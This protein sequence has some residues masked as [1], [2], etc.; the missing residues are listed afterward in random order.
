MLSK[1][2][3]KAVTALHHKK[4]RRE[5]NLFIAEGDKVVTE[6]LRA[7]WNVRSLYATDEFFRGMAGEVRTGKDTEFTLVKQSELTRI[8]T[9]TTPQ[10]VLAVVEMKDPEPVN[11]EKGSKLV[12]DMISDPG[13]LGTIIRAADWF[14]IDEVICINGSA[15]LYNPKVVQA[16]MGSLF[17]MKISYRDADELFMVNLAN[18]SLPVYGTVLDG[19]SLYNEVPVRDAFIVVGNEASGIPQEH[20]RYITRR[21]T[22]PRHRNSL[23]ESLNAAVA[24]ALVCAH[25]SKIY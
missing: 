17:R 21:I 5:Q 19:Q 4:F 15:E 2:H 18:K 11:Y 14:G 12:C 16:S 22:I 6:L 8:S 13:N 25:F 9:L 10:N 7:G 20:Y 1:S 24:A 3:I 23:A